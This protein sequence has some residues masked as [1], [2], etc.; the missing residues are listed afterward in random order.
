MAVIDF[1]FWVV[2]GLLIFAIAYL[3]FLAAVSLFTPRAGIPSQEPTTRFTIL[4][5]AHNEAKI[6][7]KTLESIRR[8]HYPPSLFNTLVIA[9]NCTDKTAQ[10]AQEFGIR[11]L[12]RTD[13]KRQGKGF[14]LEWTCERLKESQEL[15]GYDAVVMIDADTILAPGFLNAIDSRIKEGEIAIQGYYDVINPEASPMASL[16]YL[17]FVLSRNFRYKGRTRLGWSSNLLGSGMCFSK[18]VIR[19][20]GWTA[21]SIVEDVEYAVMLNLNGIKVSFAPEARVYAEIPATFKEGKIQRSR[22][23]IGKFQI[24]NRYVPRL[25]KEAIRKRDASYL[26]TA[27]ELLI[28]PFSLFLILCFVFFGLFMA[29]SYDGIS[30]LSAVWFAIVLSISAYVLIGLVIAKAHWKTYANLIYAPFFL[31]WRIG[32]LL[33]GYVFNVGKQWLK[34]ARK[35]VL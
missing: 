25:L 34:T 3:Y 31:I 13:K 27:M 30:A 10:I 5:P 11:C 32:T 33:W 2:G 17:G 19:R 9:D 6:I 18:E 28:P 7:K 35:G 8:V 14:A 24:R 21:T 29:V 20:F 1:F 23:D 26:D 12:E 15:E 4:I 16:S 22:W